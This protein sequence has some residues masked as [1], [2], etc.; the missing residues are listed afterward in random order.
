[1]LRAGED[2]WGRP[3]GR[4][5]PHEAMMPNPRVRRSE[6]ERASQI[7][8]AREDISRHGQRAGDSAP[9]KHTHAQHAG[10]S[11]AGS[12]KPTQGMEGGRRVAEHIAEEGAEDD[13]TM[14]LGGFQ[15]EQMLQMF[16]FV[17]PRRSG[18]SGRRGRVP[19]R[20]ARKVRARPPAWVAEVE[21][22][23]VRGRR[24]SIALG[25]SQQ[26]QAGGGRGGD[27]RQRARQTE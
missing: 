14:Y 23:T 10:A 27:G 18:G 22:V 16:G 19:Q 17:S 15:C 9:T 5:G 13:M 12:G 26:G 1:V 3:C 20:R 8:A 21:A 11:T 7:A 2:R 25:S 6:A 4:R 24:A